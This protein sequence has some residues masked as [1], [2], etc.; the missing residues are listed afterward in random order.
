MKGERILS[1]KLDKLNSLKMALGYRSEGVKEEVIEE[2]K[3]VTEDLEA[4]LLDLDYIKE[5]NKDECV[6]E[7]R[8]Y[9]TYKTFRE[10]QE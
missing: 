2:I 4:I 8:N 6:V 3:E 7:Y 10:N 1:R 5:E 9:K